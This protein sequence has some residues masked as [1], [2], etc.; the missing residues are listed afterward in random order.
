MK[1]KLLL[2]AAAICLIAFVSLTTVRAQQW[3]SA[4][5]ATL[6]QTAEFPAP[7]PASVLPVAV[8][9]LASVSAALALLVASQR[10]TAVAVRIR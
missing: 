6:S 8:M 4:A 10:P 7:P 2:V 9:C 1:T 5:M 3:D